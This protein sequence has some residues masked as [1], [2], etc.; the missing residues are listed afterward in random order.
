MI[1]DDAG[2]VGIGTPTPTARLTVAGNVNVV[3]AGNGII[4]SDGSVLTSG[5]AAR[6]RAIT[7]LAGCDTCSPLSDADDQRTIFVNLIG[8]MT[9]NSVTCFSDAGSP[10]VNVQRDNGVAANILTSDL[11]CSATGATSTAINPEQGTLNLNDQIHFVMVSAG[12]VAK[13][14]TVIIKSTVN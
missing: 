8:A 13:R 4:F 3:G 7:Y 6:I 5:S 10:T 11:T 14:V 1:V 2:N 9:I 12:G